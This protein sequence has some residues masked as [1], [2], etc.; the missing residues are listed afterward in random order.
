MNIQIAMKVV[1]YYIKQSIIITI[2][3]IIRMVFSPDGR[4]L[5]TASTDG[6]YRCHHFLSDNEF[7]HY[8]G[9]PTSSVFLQL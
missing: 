5:V 2:D 6:T 1:I 9:I 8:S 3:G 4:Y 7:S